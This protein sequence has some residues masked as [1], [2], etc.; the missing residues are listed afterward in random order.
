M[1]T[2]LDDVRARILDT[3]DAALETGPG[4]SR[5]VMELARAYEALSQSP[6]PRPDEG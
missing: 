1:V 3:I 6:P 2:E 5:N 4:A